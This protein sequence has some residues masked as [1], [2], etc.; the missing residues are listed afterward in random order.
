LYQWCSHPPRFTFE[1]GAAPS[2][3]VSPAEPVGASYGAPALLH[4]SAAPAFPLLPI[5]APLFGLRQT[6]AFSSDILG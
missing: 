4:F 5:P 1:A 6:N 2:V 3:D